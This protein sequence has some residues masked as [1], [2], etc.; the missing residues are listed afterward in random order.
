VNKRTKFLLGIGVIAALVVGWQ[1]AAFAVHDTGA[2]ELEGNAKNGLAGD[3]AGDDWDNVCHQ[4]L[5]NDCSTT[6]NTNG[7]TAVD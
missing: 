5:G 3:P 6:N 4:V 7:A 2:F 1:V